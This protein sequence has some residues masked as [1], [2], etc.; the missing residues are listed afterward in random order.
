MTTLNDRKRQGRE[1]GYPDSGVFWQRN[2]KRELQLQNRIMAW[3]M[4]FRI[5]AC[6]AASNG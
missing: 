3:R 4:G 1:I 6:V 5:E 2:L